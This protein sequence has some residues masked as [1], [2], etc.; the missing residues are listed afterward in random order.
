VVARLTSELLHRR[1]DLRHHGG[2]V[3]G[4]ST[5]SASTTG[6]WNPAQRHSPPP[7]HAFLPRPLPSGAAG[8]ERQRAD[9]R[10]RRRGARTRACCVESYSTLCVLGQRASA[11]CAAARTSACATN[12]VS[13]PHFLKRSVRVC[14]PP[15][16]G[17][18]AP[19]HRLCVRACVGWSVHHDF[20]H[21]NLARP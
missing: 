8:G 19:S 21:R 20:K 2:L 13:L 7:A 12:G 1:A 15:T 18:S 14:I 11:E 17:G 5:A 3:D 4:Y 6:E 9:C 16:P 10:M